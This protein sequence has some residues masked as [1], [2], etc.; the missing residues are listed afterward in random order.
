MVFVPYRW[1][2]FQQRSHLCHFLGLSE[3][4]VGTGLSGYPQPPRLGIP[5]DPC[6]L[7]GA[8]VEDMQLGAVGFSEEEGVG[9]RLRFTNIRSG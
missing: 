8:H 5:H 3:E 9:N 6:S 4:I 1:I 2:H 7:L